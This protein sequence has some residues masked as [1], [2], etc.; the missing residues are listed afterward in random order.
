MQT[1]KHM[2]CNYLSVFGRFFSLLLIVIIVQS[3]L[4]LR[5]FYF[6]LSNA[7]LKGG[8]WGG[9][10]EGGREAERRR[11]VFGGPLF[12]EWWIGDGVRGNCLVFCLNASLGG[13][14]ETEE[15]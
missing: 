12:V 4:E 8:G 9:W 6:D 15:K 14:Q 5:W 7:V 2:D 1:K 10:R 11:R 3:S 13:S